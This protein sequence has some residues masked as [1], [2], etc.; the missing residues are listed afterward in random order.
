VVERPRVARLRPQLRAA[1]RVH[2][3]VIVWRVLVGLYAAAA[4]AAIVIVNADQSDAP[5][6]A[7][8][9]AAAALALG[10]GTGSG[11]GLVV[12][13]FLVPLALPFGDTNQFVGAD[14]T[15]PV[16]LLA[17]VST[18]FSTVLILAAAGARV[19]YNR[20]RPDGRAREHLPDGR[21]S[22]GYPDDR[23]NEAGEAGAL[24]A[25]DTPS[26][27]EPDLGDAAPINSPPAAHRR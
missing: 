11:W 21:A 10:W 23:A 12:A 16:A 19:L 3:H 24:P 22:E 4:V 1:G 18:G 2:S 26:A 25:P 15:D 6:A 7:G 5:A 13:W 8:I 17:V 9:M 20:H 27:L 14:H